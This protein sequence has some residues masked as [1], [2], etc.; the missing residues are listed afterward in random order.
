MQLSPLYA[1][2]APVALQENQD[3]SEAYE[4]AGFQD[5]ESVVCPLRYMRDLVSLS[6]R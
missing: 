6:V 1:L 3:G 2:A 4:F 5:M